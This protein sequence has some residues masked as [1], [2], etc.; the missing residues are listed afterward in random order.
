MHNALWPTFE[1]GRAA[2]QCC[3]SVFATV[4]SPL[5]TQAHMNR[6]GQDR[7]YTVYIQYFGREITNIRSYTVYIYGFRP[8]LHMKMHAK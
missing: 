8:T 2:M 5:C 1:K 6:V 3:L 7:N 4:T